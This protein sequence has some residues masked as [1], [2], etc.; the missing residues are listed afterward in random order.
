MCVQSIILFWLLLSEETCLKK[1]GDI[2]QKWPGEQKMKKKKK[3]YTSH[4]MIL[5]PISFMGRWGL[6]DGM[7]KR[8]CSMFYIMFWQTL[9]DMA[10]CNSPLVDSIKV[11]KKCWE[12]L[13]K[14]F[15]GNTN[16][17]QK[18]T[19]QQATCTAVT[20]TEKKISLRRHMSRCQHSPQYTMSAVNVS[21]NHR[22]FRGWHL[23]T[24]NAY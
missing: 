15:R 13:Q 7:N 18:H 6:T 23:F 17:I 2:T 10:H 9:A 20:V 19:K 12:Y 5:F 4:E 24:L 21:A 22:Y 3:I 8:N 1:R 16:R 14:L 11:F